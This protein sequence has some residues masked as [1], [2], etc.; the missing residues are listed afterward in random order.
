MVASAIVPLKDDPSR[1]GETHWTVVKLCGW[2]REKKAIAPSSRT[3]VRY[4]HEHESIREISRPVPEPP[5]REAWQDQRET[6]TSELLDLVKASACK[7][8]FGD[9]AGFEGD[10]RS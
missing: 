3:L 6:F 7:V 9:E 5:N 4:L 1:A 2:S 10:P 8:F